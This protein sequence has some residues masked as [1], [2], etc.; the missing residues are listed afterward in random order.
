[1]S[2]NWLEASDT[3]QARNVPEYRAGQQTNKLY[4]GVARLS[5]DVG[6]PPNGATAPYCPISW[7]LWGRNV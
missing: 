4:I 1:M 7:H 2:G 6:Q 3:S 5:N